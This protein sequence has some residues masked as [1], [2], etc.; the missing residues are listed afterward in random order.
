MPNIAAAIMQIKNTSGRNGKEALLVKY[1]DLPGFKDVLHFIYNPY[2][3]TGIGKAKLKKAT[4]LDPD[5]LDHMDWKNVMDYLMDHDTGRAI[6]VDVAFTFISRFQKGSDMYVV[7]EG[8]VTQ[9]L[10]I[11]VTATTLN[12]VYGETFI[13]LVGIMKAE[14]YADFKDKV[15]GPYIATEK[16]DGARRLIRKE[17]GVLTITTRSGIPD[18][19]LVDVEREAVHLP[20]NC[21][22]DGELKAIGVFKNALELRQATNAIANQ[23]GVKQGLTFNAFD[24]IPIA[25]YKIGVSTNTAIERKVMLSALFGDESLECL[26]PRRYKQL[27]EEYQ[28]PF[29]FNFIKVVPILGVVNTEE[30]VLAMARPIWDRG[31]EGL[32]LN[33]FKGLY[34][35]RTDR[36]RQI[37]KV[38]KVEDMELRVI[39]VEEG[40]EGHQHEGSLGALIVDYKGYRV[41]VGSGLDHRQRAEWWADPSKILG[42]VIE[43]E[44]FGET[45]NKQGGLSLNCAIFK[46]VAGTE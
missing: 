7:A 21:V 28:I 14:T 43:V 33:T 11:G 36:S 18:E 25:D 17:N 37:L 38:K 9:T 45:S 1:A 23:K 15:K 31:F 20:D 41:G 2:I 24:M 12:N 5:Q 32:M 16:I 42:R 46:R 13:P 29:D 39:D 10:K 40:K 4:N 19:G 44:T 8:L 34:D 6:D 22:F 35:I 3:R 26:V 30:E 27:I